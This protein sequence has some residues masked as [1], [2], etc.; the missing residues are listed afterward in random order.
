MSNLR[1]TR[2]YRITMNTQEL[3]LRPRFRTSPAPRKP[4]SRHPR[5]PSSYRNFGTD[6]IEAANQESCQHQVVGGAVFVALN[7][8]AMGAVLGVL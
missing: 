3:S 2:R 8:V 6:F 4:N 7:V 5:V 1:G